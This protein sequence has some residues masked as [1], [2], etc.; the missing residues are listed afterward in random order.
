[1]PAQDIAG[2]LLGFGSFHSELGPILKFLDT[3]LIE[4]RF[5]QSRFRLFELR[6]P[7]HVVEPD[8]VQT[9]RC[10]E[11]LQSLQ[12]RLDEGRFR[13]ANPQKP[14]LPRRGLATRINRPSI[15]MV[16]NPVF[17][18]TVAPR[19]PAVAVEGRKLSK[20]LSAFLASTPH[21]SFINGT[22]MHEHC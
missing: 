12:L 18:L 6:M 16:L 1:M 3:A 21:E 19:Q 17:Q 11:L 13:R 4:T 10:N 5:R 20:Y 8:A 7:M 22:R 2:P 15:G 14:T 9:V